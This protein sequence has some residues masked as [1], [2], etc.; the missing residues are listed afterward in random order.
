MIKFNG[1]PVEVR[2]PQHGPP[3]MLMHELAGLSPFC[4][5]FAER[6]AGRGFRVYMPLLLGRVG[7]R[8][9]VR[10]VA[11]ICVRQE[12]RRLAFATEGHDEA[13]TSVALRMLCREI[14]Q[15]HPD[16]PGIGVIGMCLTGGFAMTMLLDSEDGVL[17]AVASQPSM[18]V[19]AGKARRS[20]VGFGPLALQR[21]KKRLMGLDRASLLTL[22]FE[23]DPLCPPERF[24]V[25]KSALD[26]VDCTR[27]VSRSIRS[28]TT[29]IPA[30]A[31]AV[32]TENYGDWVG[33]PTREA[34]EEVVSLLLARL[35]E[36]TRSP[37]A[38]T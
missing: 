18:P 20:S 11:R 4:L 22:R 37:T 33:H 14:A 21:L 38:P 27:Y 17:V 34:F 7:E 24:D 16:R 1:Q 36:T 19:P 10:N 23:H 32:L 6:L 8:S 26:G 31:H 12:F 2:G 5:A 3:V 13:P 30:N 9:I 25:L 15:L 28:G 29:G 35:A